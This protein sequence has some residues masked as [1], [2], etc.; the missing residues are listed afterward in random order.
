MHVY[1]AFGVI[2]CVYICD[3]YTYAYAALW[4]VYVNIWLCSNPP[5]KHGF[6]ASGQRSVSGCRERRHLKSCLVMWGRGPCP[7]YRWSP[8]S[9]VLDGH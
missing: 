4:C 2:Y 1:M 9:L 3:M 8:W 6:V 7:P 5:Y